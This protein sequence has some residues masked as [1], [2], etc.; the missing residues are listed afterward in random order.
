MSAGKIIGYIFAAITIFFGVLF[1][2][3]AFGPEEQPGN[4][5]IGIVSAGIGFGLIWYLGRKE[6][7][8]EEEV[9]LQIDLSGDVN[10]D[11]LTCQ[12]CGGQLSADHIAMVAGA[13]GV[14]CP[15]CGT[16]Y[17]LTEEPKW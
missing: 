13:P 7:G 16:S 5:L 17:Q 12:S 11:T 9:K 4:I 10:L 8:G 1:V 15:F 3:S 2:W 6:P 14:S